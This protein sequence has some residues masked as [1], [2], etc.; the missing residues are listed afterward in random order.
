[1]K[2]QRL[3]AVCVAIG[4]LGG[5]SRAQAPNP[6]AKPPTVTDAGIEAA[7]Q[8]IEALTQGGFPGGSQK[9]WW[10]SNMDP[11]IG[12]CSQDTG[13]AQNV[14]TYLL[15]GETEG[16]GAL[17]SVNSAL[18]SY[19]LAFA[20]YDVVKNLADGRKDLAF[21]TTAKTVMSNLLGRLGRSGKL[22]AASLAIIDYSLTALGEHAVTLSN[23]AWW[24]AYFEFQLTEGGDDDAWIDRFMQGGYDAVAKK[25][26]EFWIKT[27]QVRGEAFFRQNNPTC[28]ADY[29]ARFMRQFLLPRLKG[30]LEAEM[31]I[32]KEEAAR[33]LQEVH[34]AM[35]RATFRVF[36]QIVNSAVASSSHPLTWRVRLLGREDRVLAQEKHD[37][38]DHFELVGEIKDIPG[39]EFR[40]EVT[41]A[42]EATDK[43]QSWATVSG[44]IGVPDRFQA[45]PMKIE[46][47][48]FD[49]KVH[50]GEIH[51]AAS[52]RPREVRPKGA[53]LLEVPKP[54]PDGLARHEARL[55][56]LRQQQREG[57]LPVRLFSDAVQ[58][59]M[60]GAA[61]SF[62]QCHD[63]LEQIAQVQLHNLSIREAPYGSPPPGS[64]GETRMEGIN[65]EWRPRVEA[66]FAEAAAYQ[67][68]WDAFKK[69]WQEDIDQ[70]LKAYEK[71][72]MEA[73]QQLNAANEELQPALRSFEEARDEIRGL[74]EEWESVRSSANQAT[75]TGRSGQPDIS[76]DR[77][78]DLEALADSGLQRYEAAVQKASAATEKIRTGLETVRARAKVFADLLTEG[79]GVPAGG[80]AD[81]FARF[82]EH[83]AV[84]ERFIEEAEAAK[85][86]LDEAKVR[87]KMQRSADAAKKL[88]ARKRER[89]AESAALMQQF[90]AAVAQ[91]PSEEAIAELGRRYAV[92]AKDVDDGIQAYVRALT[93][94]AA[95][96]LP[97]G[98]GDA[99]GD[100]TSFW[101][102]R[103]A[104]L[105][106]FA[107][108]NAAIVGDLLPPPLRR[109]TSLSEAIRLRLLV[110]ARSSDF[111]DEQSKRLQSLYA[112][113]AKLQSAR[114][115][116]KLQTIA[117]HWRCVNYLAGYD[118]RPPERLRRL[119]AA[120]EAMQSLAGEVRTGAAGLPRLGADAPETAVR[121]AGATAAALIRPLTDIALPA[122]FV[123]VRTLEEIG[124][125]R[126]AVAGSGIW[127]A[128]RR[129]EQLPAAPAS[130]KINDREVLL[131]GSCVRLSWAENNNGKLTITML[132]MRSCKP[133]YA[134]NGS[135]FSP[136]D[137]KSR[138]IH[139]QLPPRP[140]PTVLALQVRNVWPDGATFSLLPDEP[141]LTILLEP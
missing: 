125:A 54:L 32:R 74:Q 51:V 48:G 47:A 120:N 95:V 128:L 27:A 22:S 87:E 110:A 132:P 39:G 121:S 5:A 141:P 9:T 99:Q 91:C 26:D 109:D 17:K 14:V 98:I 86:L 57:R 75:E 103:M 94:G 13:M 8:Q 81:L 131:D 83:A 93:Q 139:L 77:L 66:A 68:T 35:G 96:S 45:A 115:T 140:S 78:K 23:Q 113:V 60:E 18:E 65:K 71:R 58:C 63:R 16:E 102:S 137:P 33:R 104:A 7:L 79:L 72:M 12:A 62:E 82:D 61:V 116:A 34:D 64:E 37:D 44:T 73:E 117:A 67:R 126:A 46:R 88:A 25:L 105:K 90:E 130:V 24:D 89:M 42:E 127:V 133:E 30:W 29:R 84:G 43:P 122:E 124:R 70:T 52:V 28:E 50:L 129:V 111:P 112:Q 100:D 123:V 134:I 15:W 2:F 38:G 4:W 135:A 85:R 108:E 114:F 118:G 106:H 1:M 40:L 11:F 10:K 119:V 101:R 56:A 53:D 19:G 136:V 6:T 69:R 107:E 41:L 76:T 97:A 59:E 36:G 55:Q 3:A 138:E 21:F 92:V 80:P 31:M 20:A 49:V